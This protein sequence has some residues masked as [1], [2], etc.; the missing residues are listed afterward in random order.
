LQKNITQINET[1]QQLEIILSAEEYGTEY[2]QEL[3]EAKRTVQIKGFRKGHVPAGMIKKLIGP[4]IEASIA[5][6]MASRHF[7]AIAEENK[8]KTAGRAS[9]DGFSFDDDMNGI[10]RGFDADGNFAKGESVGSNRYAL[11]AG[12]NY[13]YDESTT[14]K[15][16]LRH[17]GASQPVFVDTKTG[18][19]YKNNTVLGG[20]VVVKF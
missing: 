8:I 20:S 13:L 11:S 4:S 3:E 15:L 6:K 7:A 9:I 16:E 12:L 17:D 1:E 5:E 18:R 2:N 10:G 14:L 19:Y